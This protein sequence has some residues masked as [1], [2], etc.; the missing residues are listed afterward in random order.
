[1]GNPVPVPE[2]ICPLPKV[3]A[4][5]SPDLQTLIGHSGSVY[6]VV[7]SS[8]RSTLASGSDDNTIKLWDVKT[9][10]ELQTLTGHSSPTDGYNIPV[11]HNNSN[12]ARSD[13]DPQVSL[14]GNWVFIAGET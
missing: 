1:V 5:W 10:S 2:W 13:L 8:D 14:S 9:G 11:S 6:S 7:F 3:E 12:S 4:T